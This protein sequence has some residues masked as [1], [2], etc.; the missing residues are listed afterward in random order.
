VIHAL[1]S[2]L[3]VIWLLRWGVWPKLALWSGLVFFV[4]PA[5]VE[6]V[7]W[8]SQLKT[9]GALMFAL[10]ALIA[11][12][13]M[14]AMA[15]LLFALSLLTKASGLFALPAAAAFVWAKWISG[16]AR[17]DDTIW[18]GVWLGMALLYMIPQYDAYAHLGAVEVAAYEDPLIHLRTIAAVGMRYLVMAVSGSG[19]SA[20]QDPPPAVSWLDPWWLAAV[21]T[22]AF[23]GVRASRALWRGSLEGAFWVAAAG[24][25]APVSQVF[26]FL[27]PVADRYLYFILPGLLGGSALWIQDLISRRP[28]FVCKAIAGIPVRARRTIVALAS[29]AVIVVFGVQSAS[30]AR[31]WRSET[32]LML[33]AATHYPESVTAYILSARGA[34]QRGDASAAAIALRSA[35]DRGLDRFMAVRD[36]PGL[37]PLRNDAD[38]H[39]LIG[40]MA[41]RWIE[42]ARG[43]G[44]STQPELRMLGLAHM[45]REEFIEAVT[46]F[47]AS[48]AAGG[49]L[50]NV[51]LGELA[52][53][54]RAASAAPEQT[55]D[56]LPDA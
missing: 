30:R 40:Q 3:L 20:F 23:I 1:V 8:V 36:D 22:A 16:R 37:A 34:A 53:A 7:A 55:S 19:V 13:R 29:A 17:R 11:F 50:E 49:P 2:T 9:C 54:R 14:R 32:L 41:K 33:D 6:A 21:P 56:F 48:L 26:P 31:L 27:H 52:E 42:R 12:P 18:L 10:A 44:Y 4:H 24:A 35:Y 38:F 5:N 28:R 25:F 45:V 47:E 15:A 46:A 51:V 39:A 43:R